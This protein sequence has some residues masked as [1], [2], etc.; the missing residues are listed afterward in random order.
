MAEISSPTITELLNSPTARYL[1]A[2]DAYWAV[3]KPLWDRNA[4]LQALNPDPP[5]PPRREDF[6]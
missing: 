5:N 6:K 4:F 3:I 2:M 1:R